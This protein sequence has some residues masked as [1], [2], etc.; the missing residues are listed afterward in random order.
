MGSNAGRPMD[1]SKYSKFLEYVDDL[2]EGKLSIS[3]VAKKLGVTRRT[4]YNW[5]DKVKKGDMDLSELGEVVD[6]DEEES[7]EKREEDKESI[8][9]KKERKDTGFQFPKRESLAAMDRGFSTMIKSLSKRHEWLSEVIDE[10]GT[11]TLLMALQ[12]AKIPPKEWYEKIEEFKD[13]KNFNKFLNQFMVALFEAKE[14][15]SRILELQDENNLLSARVYLLE[16]QVEVLNKKL[17][18]ILTYLNA[19]TSMLTKEQIQKLFLWNAIYRMQNEGVENVGKM[20]V[21][22]KEGEENGG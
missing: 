7:M 16:D 9:F 3:A 15:A 6:L 5:L 10:I 18:E 12:L 21:E 14:D 2:E 8:P 1:V 20:R 13:A 17:R 19:A 22:N 11:T 4:I